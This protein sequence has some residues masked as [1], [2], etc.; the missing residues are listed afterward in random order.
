MLTLAL[1]MLLLLCPAVVAEAVEVQSLSLRE[2][3]RVLAP[4]L[5]QLRTD[6][7]VGGGDLEGLA[8]D[9]NRL[10]H[11]AASA[12]QERDENG[13][14]RLHHAVIEQDF[15]RLDGLLACGCDGEA[16]AGALS[17]RPLH[18][19]VLAGD[20][21]TG[22]LER[23]L[24]AGVKADAA[25][26]KGTTALHAASALNLP[27]VA[28]LLIGAGAKPDR[29][30]AKGVRPLHTAAWANAAEAAEV[31]LRAGAKVDAADRQ[32]HTA[33]HAAA[34]A[35]SAETLEVLPEAGANPERPD[36]RGRRAQT[37]QARSASATPLAWPL[38]RRAR[39]A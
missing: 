3:C 1:P 24:A 31:L 16:E 36:A 35:D 28:S 22:C 38:A 15:E 14:T 34:A 37:A 2:R 27:H 19:S 39:A 5:E 23:L 33:C 13:L 6:Q 26:A 7:T 29:R 20:A 18:L 21:R 11:A 25:D 10:R 32:R 17:V 4:L 9:Y 8:T 30:G 12:L